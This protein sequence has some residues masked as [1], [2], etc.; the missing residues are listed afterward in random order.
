[1]FAYAIDDNSGTDDSIVETTL[2]ILPISS[3]STIVVSLLRRQTNAKP[4]ADTG[5]KKEAGKYF[6]VKNGK[7][8]K[9]S[10]KGID[11]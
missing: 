11:M 4:P 3:G 2:K 8:E 10:Q 6:I 9:Y 1:M 7:Y 5:K